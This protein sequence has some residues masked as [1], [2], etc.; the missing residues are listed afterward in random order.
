MERSHRTWCPA[1]VRTPSTARPARCPPLLTMSAARSLTAVIRRPSSLACSRVCAATNTRNPTR[2]ASAPANNAISRLLPD[3]GQAGT[4]MPASPLHAAI[5]TR[6]SMG[7]GCVKHSRGGKHRGRQ[8]DSRPSCSRIHRRSFS[9][10]STTK[11]FTGV[12]RRSLPRSRGPLR[13]IRVGPV[14]LRP[15]RRHRIA[16]RAARVSAKSPLE[17]SRQVA[18]RTGH[19]PVYPA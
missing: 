8:G 16:L 3:P 4:Q 1:T 10:G 6:A 2:W 11:Q 14:A 19:H 9:R 7:G 5:S 18:A 13:R 15:A 17:G 12:V